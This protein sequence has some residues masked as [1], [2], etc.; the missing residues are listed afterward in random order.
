MS[1]NRHH[2][3]ITGIIIKDGKYL[4]TRRSH[5]KRLFPGMWTVPGGNLEMIDY[6][7]DKK[8][9]SSHWYNVVEKVLRREIM[10]EVGLLVKNINYLTSMTMMAGDN[11]MMI[12]SLYCD[13]HEGDVILND[14]SVDHKWV[15][16]EEAKEY[17]LIEGIYDELVML[18]KIL[19]GDEV[20][21]WQSRK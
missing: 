19:K 11:P 10:E 6:V 17:E 5:S 18:D 12:L 1:D 2:I 4:I 21:E 7:N 3:A 9:T 14:E 16:L 8:D 20:N 15:T 13:H